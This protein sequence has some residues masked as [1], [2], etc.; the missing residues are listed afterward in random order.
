MSFG[1]ESASKTVFKHNPTGLFHFIQVDER[2][3]RIMDGAIRAG[4]MTNI[5]QSRSTTVTVRRS[6]SRLPGNG[7]DSTSPVF[8]FFH[9]RAAPDRNRN[10]RKHYDG[11]PQKTVL[12]VGS[13]YLM[14]FMNTC[15]S[16]RSG[17]VLPPACIFSSSQA[18][19]VASVLMVCIP[20]VSS[21]TS[22]FPAP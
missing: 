9:S 13:T 15:L 12:T 7:H 14:K 6:I 5:I 20:S 19:F 11:E 22:P 16:S 17:A 10:C 2:P 3:I 8:M 18:M 1:S 21:F 4:C